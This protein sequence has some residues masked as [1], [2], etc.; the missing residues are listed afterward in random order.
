[1]QKFFEAVAVFLSLFEETRSPQHLEL[2]KRHAKATKILNR[3]KGTTAL[4]ARNLMRHLDKRIDQAGEPEEQPNHVSKKLSG[5]SQASNQGKLKHRTLRRLGH[6]LGAASPE[7][8]QKFKK[9]TDKFRSLSHKEPENFSKDVEKHGPGY[10]IKHNGNDYHLRPEKD[11]HGFWTLHHPK[12]G[13]VGLFSVHHKSGEAE[14]HGSSLDKDERGSGLGKKAYYALGKHYGSVK[15]DPI[16]TSDHAFNV[17]RSLHKQ[18][19]AH[20]TDEKNSGGNTRYKV[21]IHNVQ[22]K[23]AKLRAMRGKNETK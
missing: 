13:E 6:I 15:S 4:A 18:G 20:P 14:V 21:K 19:W 11:A 17:Y 23:A 16:S 5:I 2:L 9:S 12:K 10:K 22:D 3:S 1:M 7:Q 8:A